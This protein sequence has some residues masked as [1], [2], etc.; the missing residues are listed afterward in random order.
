[1]LKGST[2]HVYTFTGAPP[3]A[4]TFQLNIISGHPY[5]VVSDT[6]RDEIWQRLNNAH[7]MVTAEVNNADG[8]SACKAEGQLAGGW[9]PAGRGMCLTFWHDGCRDV[10]FITSATYQLRVRVEE[11]VERSSAVG[12]V[13]MFVG[14]GLDPI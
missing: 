3:S 4:M 11:S 10:R 12:A 2:E 6:E 14:G 8:S 1:M 9:V 5:N 13:P 7:V